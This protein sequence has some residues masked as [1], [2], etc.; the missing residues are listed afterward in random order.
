MILIYEK[1]KENLLLFVCL[2]CYDHL[3]TKAWSK[4]II[5]F[6][7]YFFIFKK[8]IPISSTNQVFDPAAM[9]IEPRIENEATQ[10]YQ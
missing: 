3:L 8:I 7:N 10:T 1:E 4:R 5:T 2:L 9:P 6:H